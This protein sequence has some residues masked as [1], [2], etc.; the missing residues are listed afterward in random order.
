MYESYYHLNEKPFRIVPSPE[1]L[2]LSDKHQTA[3]TYL[4]YELME[5]VGVIC[6][7][8]EI[9][10]GKTTLIRHILNKFC[11][12]MAVSAVFNTN[13]SANELIDLVL[14]GFDI[15]CEKE[16]KNDRI[17]HLYQ[18]LIEKYAEKKPCLVIIDE[19]QNL[20][21]DALEEVRMLSNLQ[22]DEQILLQILLVGQPNLKARLQQPE[23][24][25]LTKRVA[26]T[27]HLSAMTWEESAAHMMLKSPIIIGSNK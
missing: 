13:V 12:D 8:G 10:M 11:A 6:L 2:Y 27:Y 26:V 9:G 20:S 21:I 7:T 23:L 17:E 15:A 4:E 1:Y 18:L 16:G 3:L 24:L 19:A 5:D 22:S 14:K 25:Q